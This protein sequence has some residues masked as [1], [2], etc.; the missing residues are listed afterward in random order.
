MIEQNWPTGIREK[1][2]P[3]P[4]R[5]GNV[6]TVELHNPAHVECSAR[7]LALPP[8][9]YADAIVVAGCVCTGDH[10]PLLEPKRAGQS[11]FSLVYTALLSHIA[12]DTAHRFVF[13]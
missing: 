10:I 12:A 1:N 11:F 4:Q 5:S 8:G 2:E 6:Q 3:N 13:K 7:V 9:L